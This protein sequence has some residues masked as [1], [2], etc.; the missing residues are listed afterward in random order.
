MPSSP[1]KVKVFPALIVYSQE[2]F[3]RPY[4]GKASYFIIFAGKP[5]QYKQLVMTRRPSPNTIK[6]AAGTSGR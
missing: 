5:S 2:Y 6:P 4:S 1:E 3:F